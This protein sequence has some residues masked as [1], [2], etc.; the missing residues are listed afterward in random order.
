MTGLPLFLKVPDGVPQFLEG[1]VAGAV[2]AGDEIAVEVKPRDPL[3]LGGFAEGGGGR[4][5]LER[6]GAVAGEAG[7]QGWRAHPVAGP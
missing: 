4:A 5:Q 6:G 7:Q 3:V 2:A 1:A